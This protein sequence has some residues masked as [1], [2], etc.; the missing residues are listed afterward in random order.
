MNSLIPHAYITAVYT[1]YL[2]DAL[3]ISLKLM[4]PTSATGR[5]QWTQEIRSRVLGIRT[6]ASGV[7]SSMRRSEEHTSELQSHSDVVC[8]LLLEKKHIVSAVRLPRH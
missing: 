7:P 5:P 2:H 6:L 3:P 4:S 1:L 8:R